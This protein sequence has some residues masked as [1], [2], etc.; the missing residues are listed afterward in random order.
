[1]AMHAVSKLVAHHIHQSSNN[2]LVVMIIGFIII[3][4]RRCLS[5]CAETATYCILIV[6][7]VISIFQLLL[8]KQHIFGYQQ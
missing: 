6:I 8:L 1:M 2:R 7:G 4:R 5:Y 3:V